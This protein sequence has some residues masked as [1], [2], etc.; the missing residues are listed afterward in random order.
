MTLDIQAISPKAGPQFSPNLYAWLKKHYYGKKARE[1]RQ[2]SPQVP[3]VFRTKEGVLYVGYVFDGDLVGSRLN[4]ILCSGTRAQVFCLGGGRSP[5]QTFKRIV[6]FWP[7]YTKLGRCHIDPKH[8]S[9]FIDKRW[10]RWGAG[11]KRRVCLWC[12]LSQKK[13]SRKKTVVVRTWVAA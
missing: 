7:K 1:R 8:T 10:D 6:N 11:A 12:G 2:V 3:E 4:T 9:H 5:K 13:V